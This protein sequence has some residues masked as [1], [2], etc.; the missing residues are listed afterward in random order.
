MTH[1]TASGA[2]VKEV[3]VWAEPA[4]GVTLDALAQE[5][6]EDGTPILRVD[7]EN[8]RIL[9]VHRAAESGLFCG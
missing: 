8:N 1:Y 9:L 6:T 2:R 7:R 5:L 3:H 4:D